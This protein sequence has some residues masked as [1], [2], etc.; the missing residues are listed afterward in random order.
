L[1]GILAALLVAAAGC[2]HDATRDVIHDALA[3]ENPARPDAAAGPSPVRPEA[4]AIVPTGLPPTDAPAIA[5]QPILPRMDE[6]FS[7]RRLPAG[8]QPG[9]VA[10]QPADLEKDRAGR[11]PQSRPAEKF[12]DRVH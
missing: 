12:E 4:L 11:A 1:G 7:K 8:V 3:T 5:P 2:A 6:A 10:T 9:P